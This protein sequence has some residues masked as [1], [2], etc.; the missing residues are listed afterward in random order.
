M[1]P[2]VCIHPGDVIYRNFMSVNG[3]SVRQLALQLDVDPFDL[4]DVVYGLR[5]VD[6]SLAK[7]LARRFDTSVDEWLRLQALH[8]LS[9]AKPMASY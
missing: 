6:E 9:R 5:G 8:D 4:Q 1:P 3:L 2:R 7:R